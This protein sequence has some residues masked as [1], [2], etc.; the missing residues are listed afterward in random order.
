MANVINASDIIIGTGKM[1]VNGTDVGQLDGE[2]NFTHGKTFYEKKS[3]F[4]ASTVVSVLTEENLNSDFSLLEANLTRLRTMMSEYSQLTETAAES[5]SIEETVKVYS[6]KSTRLGHGNITTLTSVKDTDT[7]PATLV[8]GTDFYIDPISG[9]ISRAADSTTI[10]DGDE[11]VVTYKYTSYAGEG[12]GIGGASSTSDNFL[13]EFIHKRRDGKYRVVRLWKCQ[14][15]GDFSMKFQEQAESP[16]E[17]S[18][19]AVADSSKAAGRQFGE[20]LDYTTAPYGG[21]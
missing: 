14:I 2:V 8:L 10:A 9:N 4:P 17:M 13:V 6:T 11:V 16:I 20:V 18:I 7:V 15:S 1:Y 21:W 5:S 12:F 19:T 3:G